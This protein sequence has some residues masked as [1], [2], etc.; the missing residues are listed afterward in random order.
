MKVIIKKNRT[1]QSWGNGIVESPSGY[2]TKTSPGPI[3]NNHQMNEKLVE[4][5]HKVSFRGVKI[6]MLLP[7]DLFID[8][9][10]L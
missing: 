3:K 9:T 5:A 2:T 10:T 6:Y 7:Y 4:N 1:D 8:L